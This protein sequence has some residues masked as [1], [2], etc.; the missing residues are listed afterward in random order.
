MHKTKLG[1]KDVLSRQGLQLEIEEE[2]IKDHGAERPLNLTQ[3]C[4]GSLGTDLSD[5]ILR[6]IGSTGKL[7]Q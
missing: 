2:Y 1:V 7:N 6:I 3:N 4:Q 5:S